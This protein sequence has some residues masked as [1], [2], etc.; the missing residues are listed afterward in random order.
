MALRSIDAKLVAGLGGFAVGGKVAREENR[1]AGV[2]GAKGQRRD[3]LADDVVVAAPQRRG[4]EI[5]L[6]EEEAQGVEV[7]DHHLLD[8][9]ALERGEIGLAN[10]GRALAGLVRDHAAREI[11]ELDPADVADDAGIEPVADFP[12]GRAEAPVVVDHDWGCRREAGD[13]GFGL[14]QG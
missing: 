14:R 4:H 11:V 9:E 6:A 10:E 13:E 3:I 8:E 5:E 7:V 1:H 12:V 2:A